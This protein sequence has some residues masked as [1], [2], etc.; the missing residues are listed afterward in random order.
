MMPPATKNYTPKKKNVAR[1]GQG[2][3]RQAVLPQNVAQ[4]PDVDAGVVGQ[5]RVEAG[6]N[7]VGLAHGNNVAGAAGCA[8]LRQARLHLVD[9]AGQGS[10]DGN[11][12]G[13]RAQH[14]LD[15]GGANKDAGKGRGAGAEKGEVQV[16]DEAL[17]LAAKVVAVDADSEPADELL[18]ALFGGVGLVRKEDE[19]GAG[20]PDGLGEDPGPASARGEAASSGRAADALDKV[21]QGLEEA[22]LGGDEGHCGALAA[23]DDEGVAAGELGGRAHL[24]GAHGDGEL[25]GGAGDEGDVLGEAALEGEDADDGGEAVGGDARLGRH[26]GGGLRGREVGR[27]RTRRRGAKRGDGVRLSEGA[28]GWRYEGRPAQG[29]ARIDVTQLLIGVR[30]DRQRTWRQVGTGS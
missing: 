4:P 5:L 30:A 12:V 23:G 26:G 22:R 16:G 14:L 1:S 29:R 13:G 3:C 17:N 9:A 18:A 21:A 19:A 28:R 7:H 24:E 20:A 15:D 10:E 27:R 2:I 25:L 6:A 11:G 8:R